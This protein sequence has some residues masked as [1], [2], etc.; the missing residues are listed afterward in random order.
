MTRKLKI[1]L[2][3]TSALAVAGQQAPRP[4]FEAE[5]NLVSISTQ[6]IDR[7]TRQPITGL[8]RSEFQVLDESLPSELVVFDDSPAQLDLLLLV[9]VS[10]GY[11]NQH[12]NS[13]SLA[14][15]RSLTAQDR[16]GQ[17]RSPT[18]H[19]E[20]EPTSQMTTS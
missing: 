6:V 19:P 7:Q 8:V 9:D 14:L 15:R 4:V 13:C 10:G 2:L 12:I 5:S 16:I 18:V 3:V 20:R 17:C 1:A 11:T